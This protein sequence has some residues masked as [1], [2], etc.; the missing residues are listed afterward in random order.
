MPDNVALE[1]IFREL[2][3]DY[4]RKNT[5]QKARSV[6]NFSSNNLTFDHTNHFATWLGGSSLRI[7][8]LNFSVDCIFSAS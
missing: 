2:V 7:Y 1:Q 3:D 6:C 5:E 4:N 8:A